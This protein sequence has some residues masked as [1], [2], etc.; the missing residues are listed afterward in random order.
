MVNGED[1]EIDYSVNLFD[2]PMVGDAET[3]SRDGILFAEVCEHCGLPF[4]QHAM[5]WSCREG[6]NKF[7]PARL[8]EEAFLFLL[9]AAVAGARGEL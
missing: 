2:I 8:R 1:G 4:R 6:G 5:S 7:R 3:G 9:I